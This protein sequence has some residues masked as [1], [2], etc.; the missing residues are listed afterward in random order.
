MVELFPQG[1][2][3]R[4]ISGHVGASEPTRIRL[5]QPCGVP[6]LASCLH[7]HFSAP[8]DCSDH[9]L[10]LNGWRFFRRYVVKEGEDDTVERFRLPHARRVSGPVDERVASAGNP[11]TEPLAHL[12][13]VRDG[14]SSDDHERR[15]LYLGEPAGDGRLEPLGRDLVQTGICSSV[16]GL[17]PVGDRG[18]RLCLTRRPRASPRF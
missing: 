3:N 8:G 13:H 14:V 4:L 18:H 15:G 2:R 17:L 11:G 16:T 7:A 5:S 6:R 12:V 1:S 9:S 10:T